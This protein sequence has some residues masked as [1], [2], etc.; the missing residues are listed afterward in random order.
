M[1]GGEYFME[2]IKSIFNSMNEGFAHHEIICD[3]NGKPCNYRFIEVNDAF[4]KI[5]G[6]KEEDIIGKTVL[7]ALPELEKIWIEIYGQVALTGETI[8]FEQ[9]QKH[10][11]KHFK[12]IAFSN[13]KYEFSVLFI[14]ITDIKKLIETDMK[15]KMI[16]DNS[17]DI[18]LFMDK[19]GK[20]LDANQRA[21]DVYGYNINE[22]INM[23]IKDI[24]TKDTIPLFKSQFEQALLGGITFE[25]KHMKKDGSVFPVEV[26][27]KATQVGEDI[28]I[29]SIVRDISKRREIESNLTNLANNDYL[30]NIPNRRYIL[31]NFSTM[32]EYAKRKNHK[33]AVLFFDINKFKKINDTYGHDIGDEVLK[34]IAKRISGI[35]SDNEIFGRIGGDEFVILQS[36]IRP[37]LDVLEMIEKIIK[38]FNKPI[39]KEDFTIHIETSIGISIFPD[40][41]EDKNVLMS[42]SDKAMYNAKVQNGN[43]YKFYRDI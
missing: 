37:E 30:T 21:V 31:N 13:K 24:R 5:T 35:I 18:I 40:D 41:S 29:M 22:L 16:F 10:L 14:D 43:S 1:R 15:Y 19:E 28:I 34:E 9:Y 7:D 27:S 25:T 33:L 8:K 26:G 32:C 38:E 11:N 4:G 17:K 36:C 12:V 3:E 23:T 20:I 39:N 6:F 42:F 2:S